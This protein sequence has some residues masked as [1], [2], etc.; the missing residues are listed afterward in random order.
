MDLTSFKSGEVVVRN[1]PKAAGEAQHCNRLGCIAG[2]VLALLGMI[3]SG[4]KEMGV[5]EDEVATQRLL[6]WISILCLAD[7]F[8]WAAEYRTQGEGSTCLRVYGRL[9]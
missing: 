8:D 3:A 6:L 2:R 4:R 7:W 1:K 5:V 9:L